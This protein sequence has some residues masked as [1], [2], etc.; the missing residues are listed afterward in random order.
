MMPSSTQIS[1]L[2]AMGIPVWKLRSIAEEKVEV[3]VN[4]PLDT[5]ALLAR[6]SNS[7]ILVSHD[8]QISKQTNYLL[9]AMMSTIGLSGAAACFISLAELDAL[10]KLKEREI[11]QKILFLMGDGAVKQVFG[12]ASNVV[13]YRNNTHNIEQ[14]NLTA[15]VSFGL[16]ELMINPQN[17]ALAWQDLRTVKMYTNDVHEKR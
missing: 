3:S 15:I 17:K 8:S 16:D 7:I 10:T 2:Q 9:Q 14:S 5:S 6:I 11:E 1:L 4:R 12:E 13:T